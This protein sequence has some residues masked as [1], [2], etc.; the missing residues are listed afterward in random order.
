MSHLSGHGSSKR[1]RWAASPA[2]TA[3]SGTA[4]TAIMPSPVD[5]TTSPSEAATAERM[6]TSCRARADSIASGCSSHRRVLPSTSVKRK[7]RGTRLAVAVESSSGRSAR[8][9]RSVI[10]SIAAM[11][12]RRP[13]GRRDVALRASPT[14]R[15]HR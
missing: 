8:S 7:V 4:K 15:R 14:G 12:R 3:P 10:E 5:F 13:I 1:A 11:M 6:M 2:V 9:V